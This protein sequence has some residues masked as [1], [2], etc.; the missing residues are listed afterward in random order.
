MH[1]LC[2][3]SYRTCLLNTLCLAVVLP[4]LP[5]YWVLWLKQLV[6]QICRW[7]CCRA[8]AMS[9]RPTPTTHSGICHAWCTTMHNYQQ[10]STQVST[11]ACCKSI[12]RSLQ[13]GMNSL[14][15][16]VVVDPM[17]GI[18]ARQHGKPTHNFC[19]LLSIACVCNLMLNRRTNVIAKKPHNVTRSSPRRALHWPT[20]PRWH[21]YSTSDSVP[22]K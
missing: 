10:H 17:N 8:L 16:L 11:T 2:N 21:H 3:H 18:C 14:L 19:S 13:R 9:I 15:N 12:Q 5:D 4:L 6:N 22:E 20:S 1:V 7:R